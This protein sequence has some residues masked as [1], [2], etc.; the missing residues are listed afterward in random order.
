MQTCSNTQATVI[1]VFYD[2]IEKTTWS[3]HSGFL[4]YKTAQYTM[5]TKGFPTVQRFIQCPSTLPDSSGY[6]CLF[7]VPTA[8][9]GGLR[10]KWRIF[11]SPFSTRVFSPALYF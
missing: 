11:E 2:G 6:T 9:A 7:V 3:V 4:R 1:P 5:E 8:G 10:E